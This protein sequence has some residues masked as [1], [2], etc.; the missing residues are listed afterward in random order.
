MDQLNEDADYHSGNYSYELTQALGIYRDT[1][2]LA[3][4]LD[5]PAIDRTIVQER[6][7]EI[8][9]RM[10]V[11][12]DA[13]SASSTSADNE[14]GSQTPEEF[15]KAL[16]E[17]MRVK[18]PATPA[19]YYFYKDYENLPAIL[20]VPQSITRERALKIVEELESINL[21]MLESSIDVKAAKTHEITA[22]KIGVVRIFMWATSAIQD[23][24]QTIEEGH[25][26]FPLKPGVQTL[27][28]ASASGARSTQ[29]Y[30]DP[31]RAEFLRRFAPGSNT[32]Q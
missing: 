9:A 15:L 31:A 25:G 22:H 14:P 2:D 26:A 29:A 12:A 4:A 11:H 13:D 16:R 5:T 30:D 28:P 3:A 10:P 20:P 6:Y 1:L 32:P 8:A 19:D 18:L 24:R 7:P 23:L 27:G 21:C 17:A